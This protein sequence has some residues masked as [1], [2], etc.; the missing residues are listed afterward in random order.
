MKQSAALSRLPDVSAT[1]AAAVPV[2]CTMDALAPAILARINLEPIDPP[3]G[4]P[5][6]LRRKIEQAFAPR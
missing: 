6:A 3:E 2:V 4:S 1:T 5:A